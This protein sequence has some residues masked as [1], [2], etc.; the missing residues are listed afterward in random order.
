MF[1]YYLDPCVLFLFKVVLKK[2]QEAQLRLIKS[3]REHSVHM[4]RYDH[5]SDHLDSDSVWN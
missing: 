3:F 2:L 4:S 5:A 1:E